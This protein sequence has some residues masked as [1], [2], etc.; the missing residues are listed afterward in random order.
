MPV[1][2]FQRP[3]ADA[4]D[5]LRDCEPF[6]RMLPVGACRDRIVAPG[7]GRI[8]ALR[9]LDPLECLGRGLQYALGLGETPEV[10]QHLA[11]LELLAYDK[12]RIEARGRGSAFEKSLKGALTLKAEERERVL[13]LYKEV[14]FKY[15]RPDWVVAALYRAGYVD[16]RFAG[17]LVYIATA[18]EERG[19]YCG[20]RWLATRR[21]SMFRS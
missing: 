4:G 12:I 3:R 2:G 14:A 5:L 21:R 8:A 7:G 17:A 16:E 1:S 6:G 15:K 19:D 18:D 20:A 9:T 13:A 10:G 11:E